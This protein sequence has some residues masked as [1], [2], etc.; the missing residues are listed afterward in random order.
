MSFD[1]AIRIERGGF[2]RDV[3]FASPDAAGVTALVGASGSGKSSLLLAVAGLVRPVSG[4][5]RV[6][7]RTLFDAAAGID[8][9][10]R[11]RRLGVLFQDSRL[12]PH[13][14]VAANLGYAC[15]ADAAAV[16]AMADRLGLA[17]LLH[18][19]PRHLSGGEA[20]RVA[21]GRALLADPVA[22]LLDEPLAHLDSDRAADLLALIGAAAQRLPVLH[23]THDRAEARDLSARIVAF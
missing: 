18:R 7:G 4:H 12:F 6:A 11:D 8:V 22:L 21:L 16:A 3:A 20:R 13:M 2:V 23:I 19:W 14:T 9:P 5:I 17:P 15:R 1:I 10:A